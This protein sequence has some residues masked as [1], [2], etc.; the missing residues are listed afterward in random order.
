VFVAQGPTWPET[1]ALRSAPARWISAARCIH[2]INA[3]E[4]IVTCVSSGCIRLTNA[5]VSDLY[6][7]VNVGTKVIVQPTDR[8]ADN[9]DSKR[10]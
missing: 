7:R 4:T 3:P 10:R 5:D 8:R 1:S 6:A 9:T 2:G